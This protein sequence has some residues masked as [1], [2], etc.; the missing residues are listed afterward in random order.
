MGLAC[1][2]PALTDP[3]TLDELKSHARI[4]SDFTADDDDLRFWLTAATDWVQRRIG[5]QFV[6]ATFR[7]TW[8]ASHGQHQHHHSSFGMA[9]SGWHTGAASGW[10]SQH[11]QTV[12]KL[13]RQPVQSISSV[14]YYDSDDVQQTMDAAAYWTDTNSTPP[15]IVPRST[16]PC[17]NWCRPAALTVEYVA[18]YGISSTDTPAM[19]KQAVKILAATWYNQ[20]EAWLG[21]NFIAK[22]IPFGIESIC[23]MYET[24]F[25]L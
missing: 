25:Y 20:R 17:I 14:T 22:E 4:A 3:V 8:D 13:D 1:I 5:R 18:G 19:L 16:W 24:G 2:T 6:N 9:G 21:G 23:S 12:F 10:L 7:Q 11:Q 15:K